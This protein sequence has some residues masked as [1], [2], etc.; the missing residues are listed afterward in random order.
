MSGSFTPK[1]KWR[2]KQLVFVWLMLAIP[3]LQFLVFFVYVNIDS[4]II[5]FQNFDYTNQV[6]EWTTDNFRFFF[7]D[8]TQKEAIK[9]AMFNSLLVGL[10]D[11]VLVIVSA[12][13]AYFFFKKVPGRNI[14][15]IIFFLPSIISIVIYTMVFKYM[16]STDMHGLIP[17]T[18]MAFGVPEGDLPLWFSDPWL[19]RSLILV[20]CLWVGTGYNI[21]ILGGSMAN[22]PSDVME[23]SKLEGVS[24]F[25]ELFQIVI[26]MIWPTISVAFIGS[27][28]VSFTLFMQ[29]N[30]ITG[31]L[32][33]LIDGSGG[34][35]ATISFLVN[36]MIGSNRER[37]AAYGLCFT[38][39]SIPIILIARKIMDVV[40]KKL[41]F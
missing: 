7:A 41:G 34:A 30:L 13:L 9:T 29:V 15:R 10:N 24:M 39:I 38:A 26:P 35:T 5:A 33:K 25:R 8:L 12:M 19:A 11:A 37:A 32:P 17:E 3:I 18:L 36:S 20:Y 21:L 27:I 2:K 4:F 40:N 23:Y 28:S 16:F 6:T 31:G 22:I 14:F 1:T